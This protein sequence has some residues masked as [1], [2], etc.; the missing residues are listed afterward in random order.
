MNQRNRCSPN[1]ARSNFKSLYCNLLYLYD[2]RIYEKLILIMK[3]ELT[4]QTEQ[5]AEFQKRMLESKNFLNLPYHG[6]T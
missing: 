1:L 4:K 2:N 3:F 5:Q 6:S